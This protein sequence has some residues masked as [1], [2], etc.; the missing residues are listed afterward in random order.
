MPADSRPLSAGRGSNV[1]QA[2]EPAIR[3]NRR[4]DIIDSAV[5]RSQ[6]DRWLQENGPKELETLFRAIIYYPSAPILI[7]DHDRNCRAASFGASKLLGVPREE[8]IGRRLDDFA[9]PSFRPLISEGWRTFLDRGEQQGTLR[10]VAPGGD[11]RDVEY[12]AKGNVLPVRNLLVLRD[13]T[14]QKQGGRPDED[15]QEK[16]IPSWVQ[17]FALLLLDADGQIVAWYAGA[18]RMYGYSASEAIGQHVSFLFS[19]EDTL[20]IKLKQEL[21]MA[22]SD[23]HSCQEGWRVRKDGTRF[24]AN[25]ITM[26]LKND[27]GDLQ[28]FARMVRDF[29]DRHQKDEELLLSRAR[30]RPLPSESI[31]AGVVYGEFDQITEVN[32]RFLELVGYSRA[33]FLAGRLSWPGLTPSEY[34]DLDE[35]A[36][37][38]GLRFGACVPFEKELIRKDGTRVSVLVAT[39]VLKVSPFRWITFIQALSERDRS[40]SIAKEVVEPASIGMVGSSTAMK[41]I[42]LQM[43]AVAPTDATVLILG[44]SGTGKELVARAIHKMSPRRSLPFITLD[45]SNVSQGPLENELFGYERGALAG[46]MSNKVGGFEMAQ[47]GTLFLDEVG[48]IPLDLEPKLLR[49]LKEKVFERLGGSKTI[50]VDVRLL[51]ATRRNLSEM[52]G[53]KLFR[54]DFFYRL[55]VFPITI[56]PLRD[57]PED[58]PTLAWHFTKV[59]AAKMNRPIDRISPETIRAMVNWPWPGNVWELENFI[60]RSVLVSRGPSLRALLTEL[61][62]EAVGVA[63]TATLAEVEREYVLRVFRETEGV[64]SAAAARL[65]VPRTTLNALMKKLGISRSDL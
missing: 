61:R 31:V 26:A 36:C 64:I 24:W 7:T 2:V 5:S 19:S 49:A 53:D 38:E 4:S 27:R 21:K 17:D 45:C 34:L 54:S 44:E 56:P 12:I 29:S 25:V 63:S 50:P 33:D 28:G 46:T 43:E 39:A 48:D 40:G 62:G 51:A 15:P 13:K 18:E 8:I 30:P 52:T 1:S 32:D 41:R 3:E 6:A 37:E 16:G 65:G 55:K 35:L 23:G 11:L 20:R 22:T 59:Y 9:E 42:L 58:I 57:H 14:T 10:L 47:G 60:E